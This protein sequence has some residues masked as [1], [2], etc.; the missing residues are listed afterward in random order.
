MSGDARILFLGTPLF[1]VEIF[2][3]LVAA[4]YPIVAAVTQPDRRA[5]RGRQLSSPPL[6]LA[7]AKAG[8]A[9]LAPEKIRARAAVAQ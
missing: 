2:Q 1:A 8:V 7:A 4:G 5:G 6:K 3:A 9:V